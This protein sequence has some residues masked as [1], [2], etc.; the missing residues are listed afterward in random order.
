[1]LNRAKRNKDFQGGT[2]KS[3]K[4]EHVESQ[5]Q[6]A[7]VTSASLIIAYHVAFCV[8][9]G[10]VS[11]LSLRASSGICPPRQL[12]DKHRPFAG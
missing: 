7:Q 4:H 3:Q 5:S 2:A 10:L 9:R 6:N 1:M 11:L 12:V 8:L